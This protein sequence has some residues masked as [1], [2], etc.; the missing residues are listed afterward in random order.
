M[1]LYEQLTQPQRD[2]IQAEVEKYP[3][4]GRLIM[5]SLEHN[6]VIATLTI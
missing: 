4:T 1:N 3:A 6:S 5:H 2:K